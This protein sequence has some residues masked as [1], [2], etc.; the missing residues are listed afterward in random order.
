MTEKQK[1]EFRTD[2]RP[3]PSLPVK[4]GGGGF[5]GLA[6]VIAFATLLIFV[7]AATH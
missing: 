7:W 4:I 6:V 2:D 3:E 5:V 1:T